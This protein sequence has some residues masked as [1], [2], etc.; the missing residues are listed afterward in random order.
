[1]TIS[2]LDVLASDVGDGIVDTF[3]FSYAAA[4]AGDIKVYLD[5]V[6]Q[7]DGFTTTLNADQVQNPGGSVVF[8]SPPG[9]SVVVDLK[10][11]TDLTQPVAYTTY[12]PFPANTHEGALDRLTMLVQELDA[13]MDTA[14]TDITTANAAIDALDVRVTALEA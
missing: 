12:G 10:R 8:V 14:E 11:V 6:V 3:A 1:M 7:A 5:D 4:D 2:T 9:D 13:R